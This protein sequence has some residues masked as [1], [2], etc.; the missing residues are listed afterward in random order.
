MRVIRARLV[1]RPGARDR[2]HYLDDPQRQHAL[3]DVDP[4]GHG[5]RR[6]SA[7]IEEQA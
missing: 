2:L 1:T 3:V 7:E 4:H 5:A 6:T